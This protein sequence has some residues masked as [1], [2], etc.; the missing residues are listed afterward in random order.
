MKK[1]SFLFTAFICLIS[2]TAIFAQRTGQ[3]VEL[4]PSQNIAD[5]RFTVTAN[6]MD[7]DTWCRLEWPD[8]GGYIPELWF[9]DGEADDYITFLNPGSM[10]ALKFIT[11]FENYLVTGGRIY[12]GDGSFPGPFLGTSFRVLA[13]DD[14]GVDGLPGTVIDSTDVMVNNYEWVEFEGLT[15]EFADGNFYLVMKQLA[16]NFDSAPM[17]VDLDNPTYLR[18]YIN[19]SDSGWVLSP[20]Q[21]FM[22]RAWITGYNEPA[23]EIDSFEVARFSGFEYNESPLAGDTTVLEAIT[24]SEY[25]DYEWD[26]LDPGLYAYGVKTHFTNGEWSD[27]DVSNLVMHIFFPFPPTCFYQVFTGNHPLIICPPQDLYGE[28]P[29]F[30]LGFNVYVNGNLD[31][32]LPPSATS[33]LPS[34][35]QP[36]I[37]TCWLTAVYDLSLFGFP[38]ETIESSALT[39]EYIFSYGFPLPFLEQWNTGT[40]ETNN[41][42]TDGTNWSINWQEGQPLPSAEFTWDPIQ[43]DYQVSLESYPLLADSITEGDIY[44][45]FYLKL[46]NFQPTGT[47]QMLVQV[48]N[49]DSQSWATV[50][51]YSNEDG[52]FDWAAEHLNITNHAR[53][54]VFK[55]RFVASGESS[56]N[57]VG[58]YLDNIHVYRTCIGP[59]YANAYLVGYPIP[60]VKVVWEDIFGPIDEWLEW[61]NG[62]NAGISIGVGSTIEFDAAARWEP[63]QLSEYAEAV[64]EQVGFF[65][66]ES[67]AEYRIRVWIGAGAANLVVD[68]LV[69]YPVIGQWNYITL[70]TPVIID[71][72]QELWVGYHVNAQT[73]YPAGVDNGPAIDGYGNMMNFGGW[74]TLIDINPT[75]DYNWN[76]KVLIHRNN[77]N[78]EVK[79]YAIYRSDNG[80]P[81]YLRGFLEQNEFLDDSAVCVGPSEHCYKVTAIYE[82]LTDACESPLPSWTACEI[83]WLKTEENEI[84]NGLHIYPNP[85]SDMLYIEA[86]EEIESVRVIDIRG[87]T[88]ERWNSGTVK[89][90]NGGTVKQWNSGTVEIA[91]NGLAPGLYLVRVETGSGVVSRKIL[92]MK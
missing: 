60:D 78:S 36:G 51:T 34:V 30:F 5:N 13:Y 91:L 47:E 28:L 63:S 87:E 24:L 69:E 21:D 41:W 55:I 88:V 37:Y 89:Q 84:G 74:Q 75:L 80:A 2:A 39:T 10:Y 67:Q 29:D 56:L 12:V 64:V 85:A 44:L 40:F 70:S 19:F 42:L 92:I 58:W 6:V 52:S 32:Y 31:N 25:N 27:Y 65:P 73:G 79:K 18:S 68:Q 57:I 43:T 8:P 49:W 48:W 17:G 62:S 16:S 81:F 76:I 26:A 61:D 53:G 77:S 54:K 90:W 83:C 66:A 1:V 4:S 46:D 15:A 45:D 7:N 86:E 82:S 22:I 50:S 14:D 11:Y 59:G 72:N 38:N 20:L 3:V 23:R 9:D 33:Y 71:I 35:E